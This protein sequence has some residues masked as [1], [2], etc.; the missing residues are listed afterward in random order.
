[1]TRCGSLGRSFVCAV[2]LSA[3]ALLGRTPD[4]WDA[5]LQDGINAIAQGRYVDAVEI[6]TPALEEANAFQGDSRRTEVMLTLATAY[7]YHSQLQKAEALFL[8]AKRLAEPMGAGGRRFLGYALAGLAQL[9]LNQ[10]RCHEAE[11]LLRP[12][13]EVCCE[14]LGDT[15]PCTTTATRNLGDLYLM[16]GQ[17]HKA[18]AFFAQSLEVLRRSPS[19]PEALVSTL[20]GLGRVYLIQGRFTSAEPLFQEAVELSKRMGESHP[21][22]ADSLVDL[23]ELYRLECKGAR[24]EPLL[25]KAVRI[26]E[27]AGDSHIVDA[28]Y[29]LGLIAVDEAKFTTAR[30]YLERSLKMSEQLFG[31][32]HIT[33]T[34]A[35]AA[36][37]EAYLGERNYSGA[38]S[39]IQKALSTA[40]S[41]LGNDKYGLA[42]LLMIAGRVQEQQNHRHEAA[43]CYREALSIYRQS[44]S[45]DHPE[46]V[47]AEKS[48]R[49]FAKS[50]HD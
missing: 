40:R 1:M 30:D 33:T 27:L 2:V 7:Q 39:L 25:K 13:I 48:Y 4:A 9:R 15:D 31:Q 42:A 6:L 36:L 10:G 32:A 17:T 20:R 21:I 34:R 38:E 26:Y 24:A 3:V 12:A 22:Y 43:A 46:L 11:D 50:F 8:E 35:Q 18:E 29:N 14:T 44:L 28:L 23:S 37:A 19:Q 47:A 45:G 16:E 41:L 49:R 5:R